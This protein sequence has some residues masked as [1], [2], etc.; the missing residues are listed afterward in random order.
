MFKFLNPFKK[1]PVEVFAKDTLEDYSHLFIVSQEASE[2]H[3][4]M[5]DFYKQ[6]IK[7]MQN[8]LDKETDNTSSSIIVE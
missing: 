7:R 2:Y 4:K 3:A 1:P 8:L 6:G 5:A